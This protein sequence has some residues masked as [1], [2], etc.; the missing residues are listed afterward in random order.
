MTFSEKLCQLRTNPVS[1]DI[2]EDEA[3]LIRNKENSLLEFR[4]S[5]IVRV[6]SEYF[7]R[8]NKSPIMISEKEA[9]LFKLIHY[10]EKLL[11]E[12]NIILD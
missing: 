3:V 7:Y 5:D 8:Q 1:I 12:A 2:F 10:R 9:I 4:N 11:K 6:F